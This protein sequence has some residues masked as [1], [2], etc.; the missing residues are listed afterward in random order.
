MV[1]QQNRR[2][3][4]VTLLFILCSLGLI[5]LGF[6]LYFERYFIKHPNLIFYRILIITLM[7]NLMILIFLIFSFTKIS[8]TAGP[9]GPRGLRGER[10]PLGPSQGID[11]CHKKSKT[12]GELY[13]EKLKKETIIIKKPTLGN[14]NDDYY[15]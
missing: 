12:L 11:Q 10:G 14:P 9:V 15:L 4:G 8:F 5:F 13:N 2:I 6:M 7:L 1:S 3:T